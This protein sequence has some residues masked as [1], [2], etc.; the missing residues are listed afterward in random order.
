[1]P[2]HSSTTPV[3]DPVQKMNRMY[4][5]TRHVYDW[6][7]RYYL[8]GRDRMLEAIAEQPGGDVLEV[9]CGT[10]RNLRVLD[11]TA[12]QH[13]L[14]GIDASLSML[15]TARDK[16]EQENCMDRITLGHGV[17]QE[18]APEEHL[19]VDRHFDVIFFSY[20]LSMIPSWNEA[21]G[22]ALAHLASGGRLYIVDFWDQADL[23]SWA[24]TALQR[25]LSLFDVYPRPGLTHTLERLDAVGGLSCTITPVA[26][27]YAYLATIHAPGPVPRAAFDVLE[28]EA[29]QPPAESKRFDSPNVIA[30]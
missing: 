14:Y 6:S 24:A 9:G 11:R 23:P 30:A 21:L 8:L 27:R 7:R 28:V 15:A 25:W 20:V 12:P 22:A 18:L 5:W 2:S 10:A 16:V 29:P 17:A 19:G 26:R 1:M 3:E 4:R 13:A